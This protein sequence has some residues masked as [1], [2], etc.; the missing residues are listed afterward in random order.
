MQSKEKNQFVE[1][2]PERHLTMTL[3]QGKV[4]LSTLFFFFMCYECM[5]TVITTYFIQAHLLK[6]HNELTR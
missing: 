4:R 6:Y 5:S 3:F 1:I 2:F